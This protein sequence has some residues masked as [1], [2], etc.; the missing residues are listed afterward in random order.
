[1]RTVQAHIIVNPFSSGGKTARRQP[2]IIAE[3]ARRLG[4]RPTVHVTSKPLEATESTREAIRAGADLVIAV[5]GD[6]TMH[7]VVNGFA[8]Q[9]VLLN[10]KCRLGII[11]SGT[12]GDVIR[13][14][15]L[16]AKMNE[17]IAVACGDGSR[18]VDIGKVNVVDPQGAVCEHFFLNE[19]Q[20]GIA[21]VV[22]QRF[23][24]RH[25]WLGGFLGFGLTAVSTAARHREQMMSVEIDG[26]QVVSDSLLGVVV[27]NGGYAGGG[28]NFAPAAKVDDG[29]FDV[30]VLHKQRVLSRLLN[31][32]R[33]YFGTHVNLSWV[34]CFRGRHIRVTSEE[35]VPVEADGEFLGHLP[36]NIE[37]LPS[38]L[39]LKYDN[40][41]RG[42]RH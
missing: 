26:K 5:G 30:V 20:Q 39:L 34:S 6:G 13:S 32:P 17:Q 38:S 36:C 23:Q 9:G 42:P 10:P 21:A 3:I 7:E 22:V 35:N 37:V 19:C 4:V 1:M 15:G 33:I 16:P 18:A 27:S 41:T 2:A 40:L 12:A 31:F 8:D 14:F 11:G 28:M 29:L 25:K 24:S